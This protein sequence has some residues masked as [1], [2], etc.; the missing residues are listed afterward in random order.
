MLHFSSR[1]FL[2]SKMKPKKDRDSCWPRTLGAQSRDQLEAVLS[3][4]LKTTRIAAPVFVV[5]FYM[6][7]TTLLMFPLHLY[8]T[9]ADQ[10]MVWDIFF[11]FVWCVSGRDGRVNRCRCK[12]T[13]WLKNCRA[14]RR[15]TANGA[16]LESLCIN[17]LLKWFLCAP[18]LQQLSRS[19]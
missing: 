1:Y 7:F 16:K 18:V 13:M 3:K 12:A 11:L 17:L 15:A 5:I 4:H 10:C 8:L 14:N 6:S 9:N 19:I 2:L